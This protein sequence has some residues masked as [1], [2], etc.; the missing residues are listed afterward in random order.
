MRDIPG[1]AV[2]YIL[3]FY[4]SVFRNELLI[5][6]V[7][8]AEGL[9]MYSKELFSYAFYVSRPDASDAITSP[10]MGRRLYDL[11]RSS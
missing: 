8:R 7:I 5:S 4:V 2:S 6:L 11:S 1:N 9:S 3:T 10:C